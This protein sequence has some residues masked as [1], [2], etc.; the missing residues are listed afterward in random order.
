[1]HRI[2]VGPARGDVGAAWI[3][4]AHGNP[5]VDLAD[6]HGLNRMLA[7]PDDGTAVIVDHSGE[8]FGQGQIA[9][10]WAFATGLFGERLE[11]VATLGEDASL[12]DAAAQMIAESGHTDAK[13]RL[14]E[15]MIE[16]YLGALDYGGPADQLSLRWMDEELWFGAR[17]EVVVG[18]YSLLVDAMADGLDI[19]L[20]SAVVKVVV[21]DG[22][23]QVHTAT[24]V[25]TGTEV[26]VTVP[27]GVL[28]AG[29][30][31]F[32]PEL[33][34]ERTSAIERLQMGNLEKVI[35]VFDEAFW[36]SDGANFTYI[37]SEKGRYPFCADLTAPSGAP[38]LGCFTGGSFSRGG[39]AA[40][41]DAEAVAGTLANLAL[42]LDVTVPDP[43]ATHVTRWLEDERAL[44]SYSF[45]P[46]GAQ[47]SDLDLLAVPHE[48]RV[49]FA[50][51]H[52]ISDYYQTVH[53][54]MLSGVREARALGVDT[55]TV[56][57]LEQAHTHLDE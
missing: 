18:G 32:V 31:E 10:G 54:A 51:E 47:L 33:S 13:A 42:V 21:V 38:T 28:K 2:W 5:V 34:D 39:R 9:A 36:A 8:R 44:G 6:A 19:Q 16:Q 23:V 11:L 12:A 43:V 27:L 20:S 3:P 48:T 29:Y 35:L 53:G 37:D 1:M 45:V 24:E 22:G 41:T 52:T 56:L 25:V 26:V 17:D 4:G 46:V 40:A 55:S 57:G 14:R 49:R 7:D 50:G 30:I 15:L